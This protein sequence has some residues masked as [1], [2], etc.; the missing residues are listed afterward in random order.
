MSAPKPILLAET[1]WDFR[2]VPSD[3]IEACC[4]Y[5]Y[6]REYFKQSATLQRLRIRWENYHVW[7]KA[8][9]DP[10]RLQWEAYQAWQYDPH[11][12]QSKP[13]CPPMPIPKPPKTPKN[14]KIGQM[15]NHY[16]SLILSARHGFAAPT[17]F[18]TFPAV[19]WRELPTRA[20]WENWPREHGIW[21][22]EGRQ[23]R[24]RYKGDRFHIETLAQLAPP[25]IR[26]LADWIDY[27]EFFRRGQ[28]LSNTEHGFF[29]INWDYPV[30]EIRHAFGEWLQEQ[31]EKRKAKPTI[32]PSH[33]RG[34]WR[35]KLRW[36]GALRVKNHY[37]Y[38]DLVDPTDS[39]L[40]VDAPYFYYPALR[41]NAT[42]AAH[43]ISEMF[44]SEPEAAKIASLPAEELE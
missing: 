8:H 1:E 11:N 19:P 13:K 35:D 21:K 14:H 41:T 30:P 9:T 38:R 40:K 24:C 34:Q 32:N 28:N 27:H 29:A 25:N 10:L 43:L 16:A 6:S 3:E 39:S 17:D 44:P 18:H 12:K 7:R 2:S 15:A 37:R 23:R 5:E 42:R 31:A 33:S 4:L 36:L 20:R 22:A 26:S